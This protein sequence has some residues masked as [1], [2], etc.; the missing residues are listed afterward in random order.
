MGSNAAAM[1]S[2]PSSIKRE[3]AATMPPPPIGYR[4]SAAGVAIPTCQMGPV[5]PGPAMEALAP[6]LV[7]LR[8]IGIALP[9]L[10]LP[11]YEA[12]RPP[13]GLSDHQRQMTT[14]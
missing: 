4:E 6:D 1:K 7:Q 2:W 13:F 14:S 11:T 10:P 8:S 12:Q 9:L 3:E 5:N